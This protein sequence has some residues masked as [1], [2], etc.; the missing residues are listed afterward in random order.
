MYLK[1][2]IYY[3]YYFITETSQIFQFLNNCHIYVGL[4]FSSIINSFVHVKQ[5]KVHENSGLLHPYKS[6]WFA[7]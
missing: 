7:Q 6:F 2:V 3:R 5:K 4:R 1:P